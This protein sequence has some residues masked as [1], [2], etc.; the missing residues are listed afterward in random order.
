[1]SRVH[2]LFLKPPRK[3][4]SCSSSPS[5]ANVDDLGD[6][7]KVTPQQVIDKFWKQFT[8]KK[9]GKGKILAS[10]TYL[11]TSDK[12]QPQLLFPPTHTLSLPPRE[13]TKSQQ[14]PVKLLMMT[15]QQHAAPKLKR[16]SRSVVASTKDTVTLTSTLK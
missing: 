13:A 16:S 8:T 11:N 15:P 2:R 14:Q 12:L 1:M 7:S 6:R 5:G 10:I 3:M 4:S 9:P